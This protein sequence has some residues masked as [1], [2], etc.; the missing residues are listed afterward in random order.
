MNQQVE[1]TD[2]KRTMK[3]RHLFMIA[4]GGVIG[5]GLFMGSGQIV[6]NAGP[7]GAI[8]AFFVGGFVMY[9]TML[10]L[11]ELSVAMPEAGSFQSYASKFIS[12]GFGFVVGWMY[13]LN[14]AV[15][16]GVELTTVSI[17]MKRWFPDVSSWIWCV[18][19]AAALFLVNALSAKAYAEAEFWFASVKVATIVVFIVLGGAVMFGLL[20]F[21]GKPAPMLHNFTENGGLFPNGALAVLLTMITVNYSFQGTELIGIASGE[22]E[23]PEK[24]IPKAIKNTIWRTLFFFVLAISVVVGLLPWQEANLVESPFVLVFD[25]AGV[26]YAADIMNFVIITAVLSVANSGLYANSRMLWAMAK[27]GMASPAFTK[28][29]KKG[30]PLNALI[31]SLI[32]ASL[33]LLTSVFAAD[34]VFLVLTSIAAM[35]AVVVW[36][37]IAASQFFFRRNF[38]KNGGD[39]NDLKYRT[40]LYPLVPIVAFSLNFIT[41]VSLAFIPDQRIALYCGIPFMVICYILYQVKYKKI[42]TF[43][44]QQTISQEIN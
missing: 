4:L 41:F 32:F 36:M 30:V 33:S 38:V 43:E 17:L 5:T 26:P 16:V 40:P 1:Q 18:T 2:L 21:N 23:N 8:L 15:T 25:V 28:L 22:S 10:C 6:H 31:F 24:T 14:W 42:V 12:P 11:G 9:L 29:T 20:D 37:S 34:T 35:A 13:W 7:G 44:Q 39:I 19:F 27:Q 3:S